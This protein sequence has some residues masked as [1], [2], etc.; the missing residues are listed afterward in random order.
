M[1]QVTDTTIE[2]PVRR[3]APHQFEAST[4]PDGDYFDSVVRL[5]RET[6][7]L[8]SNPEYIRHVKELAD[9][10]DLGPSTADRV[11]MAA[12]YAD[13]MRHGYVFEG[14][15]QELGVDT[16]S[17]EMYTSIEAL[18]LINTIKTWAD[19]AV[20][21]T[22][23][24]RAG[25]CQLLD[26]AESSYAPLARAGV[27][28]GRDERGHAAMGLQHLRDVCRTREGRAEAQRSVERW[29]PISLDM[30]GTSTGRR[31]WKY[32]EY[33]LKTKSNEQLRNEFKIEADEVLADVGLTPP[34]PLANRRFL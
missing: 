7:E 4:I 25:G 9:M 16:T 24:D 30:F 20:F 14:V 29:Y 11:R 10:V 28:V 31:Q 32:I 19:L 6:G 18:N 21:N 12:F 5:L 22:L 34:D 13:E 26:Y 1:I 15:L 3:Y 27:Y 23:L 17:P 2:F 8:A 33:G